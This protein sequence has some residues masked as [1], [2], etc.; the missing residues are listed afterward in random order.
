MKSV[1]KNVV[2]AV[3]GA[4]ASGWFFVGTLV[5]FCLQALW[6]ALSSNLL[7]YDEYYHVGIIE[8]YSRQ[9]SPFIS[10]QPPEMS[11][12]G[13]VTRLSSYLYQYLMSFPYRL[14]DV[15]TDNQTHIII[16]LRF[17]NIA[18]IVGGIVLFRRLFL[19]AKVPQK[20]INVVTLV[21]VLTPIMP[22]LAAQ[23]NYDNMM[24]LL[25]PVFLGYAY[26]A[27][28]VKPSART[29]LLLLTTGML[30]TLTKHN[31]IVIFGS[32]TAF[33]LIRLSVQY[34]KKLVTLLADDYKKTRR[35]TAVVGVIFLLVFGLFFERFG[36]N[37]IRYKEVKVD[38]ASVQPAEVC[39]QY[40]PWRRNQR[41]LKNIPEV[42]EFSGPVSFS[43]HWVSRLM[44][45]YFAIFAN[46]VPQNLNKPDPY[47][48]YVFR[49]VL[50]LPITIGYIFLVAGGLALILRAKQL[51]KASELNQLT[52][53]ASVA[54]AGSLWVFNYAFYL[55]Y[56][57]AYAIQ[58]R[59]IIPM[60][61]PIFV[62]LATALVQVTRSSNLRWIRYVLASLILL[63]CFSG[64]IVGWVIRSQPDW[65]WPS[66]T[67]VQVN[68]TARDFLKS[69]I[70]H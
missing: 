55:K 52:I 22:I 33:V 13:D 14:L 20:I 69:V 17:I 23:N 3:N 68:Q 25:T 47:G 30:A 45:G 64:G 41:A 58:S 26:A 1:L 39:N 32:V 15:F 49:T 43:T 4:L 27:L 60:L 5:I 29:L 38:C 42:P 44:R 57:Q 31:F 24:F 37:A 65:Y 66:Q 19:Q 40:S 12:Y 8:F 62:L 50:P 9:W 10:S 16:G 7:P 21:F 36:V 28:T 54:L 67:V 51:W 56:G 6:I 48:H 2:A 34:R 18:L 46:I 59:Y 35:A 53:V 11:L 61:L 63:Y 70:P